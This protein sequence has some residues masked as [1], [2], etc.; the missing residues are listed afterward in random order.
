MS[1][2]LPVCLGSYK[3]PAGSFEVGDKKYDVGDLVKL[4]ESIEPIDTPLS[5][6][7]IGVWPW[8]PITIKNFCYHMKRVKKANMKYPIILDNEGYICDGWHRVCKAIL[9]GDTTIKAIR[10][11][12]MPDPM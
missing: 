8:G 7:Y 5:S 1:K 10:L 9:R 4:S 2:P 6:I 12:T 11:V 3:F